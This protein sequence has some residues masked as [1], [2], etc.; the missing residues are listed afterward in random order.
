MF[1]EKRAKKRRRNWK[2]EKEKGGNESKRRGKKEKERKRKQDSEMWE[3]AVGESGRRS[4]LS[5]SLSRNLIVMAWF[6]FTFS[7]D[8]NLWKSKASPWNKKKGG[9]NITMKETKREKKKLTLIIRR[10]V[11]R[12]R[13]GCATRIGCPVLS[14][15]VTCGLLMTHLVS[16]FSFGELGSYW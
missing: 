14:C 10:G 6:T 5:L 2:Q 7:L 8:R 16:T 1:G 9:K 4:P 15:K 12:E 13:N 11:H 3:R